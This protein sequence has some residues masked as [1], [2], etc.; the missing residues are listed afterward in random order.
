MH[1]NGV[2]NHQFAFSRGAYLNR[3]ISHFEASSSCAR[4]SSINCGLLG[5]V[6]PMTV[7]IADPVDDA[8]AWFL[9]CFRRRVT[10]RPA[11]P[12]H[13]MSSRPYRANVEQASS[14]SEQKKRRMGRSAVPD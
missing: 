2:P 10:L 14:K 6:S 13:S 11:V 3:G 7:C 9:G 12:G 8:N 1:R 5:M 4:R